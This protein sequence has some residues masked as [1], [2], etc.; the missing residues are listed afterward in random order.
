[1]ERTKQL[2]RTLERLAK[3]YNDGVLDFGVEWTRGTPH[4][5]LDGSHIALNPERGKDL[6]NP[7]G[8]DELRL[9]ADTTCH[10]VEHI[11]ESDL[12]SKE[13]MTKDY[14]DHPKVAGAIANIFE[15]QFVDHNRTERFPGLRGTLAWV[16]EKWQDNRDDVSSLQMTTLRY[17]EVLQQVAF[18]GSAK[19]LDKIADPGDDLAEFAGYIADRSQKVRTMM[20]PADRYALFEEVY[21]TLADRVDMDE[22]EEQIS[23]PD[24]RWVIDPDYVDDSSRDD[25]PADSD[26]GSL[27][28]L[29][30]EAPDSKMD[31]KDWWDVPADYSVD[32]DESI[33]YEAQFVELREDELANAIP[34]DERIKRRDQALA[35][36]HGRNQSVPSSSDQHSSKIRKRVYD[37][38]IAEEVAEF[39]ARFKKGDM[40]VPTD[41][42]SRL[43]VPAAT[44]AVAGVAVRDLYEEVQ[45]V[46]TGNRAIG[47][48]VDLSGS[49]GGEPI[50]EAK[51][52]LGAFALATQEIGDEFVSTG[53]DGHKPDDRPL[54]TAPGEEFEWE[55][56]DAMVG[57]G[58]TPTTIGMIDAKQLLDQTVGQ[59]Q[60]LIVLTDGKPTDAVGI[61]AGA[62]PGEGGSV[63]LDEAKTY[64]ERL[65]EEGVTVI[66]LALGSSIS[67]SKMTQMFGDHGWDRTSVTDLADT[68]L[69]IY[70][71]M[72]DVE[73]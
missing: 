1:M 23:E 38:G 49:M 13:Q 45:E 28:G 57:G 14:P 5:A 54:G 40:H 2:M 15:D 8:P 20:D 27:P 65:R 26:P 24:V 63:C 52:A 50:Y 18:T 47:I 66:G 71:D 6:F 64:V 22:L 9:L 3:I 7:K 4:A 69:D 33:D 55:H 73:R 42:G 35:G 16:I 36:S 72:M 70:A 30:Y 21:Q 39:F 67:S 12:R 53:Y 11:R 59:K 44:Q 34:L 61:A 25:A 60:I 46:E 62:D 43:N 68:L 19:G 56:L 29:G 32:D 41:R 58:G 51:T 31:P 37:E 17:W 10:E 48:A